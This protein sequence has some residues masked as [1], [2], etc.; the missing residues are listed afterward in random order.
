PIGVGWRGKLRR[1]GGAGDRD[2]GGVGGRSREGKVALGWAGRVFG[3]PA[4]EGGG[5]AQGLLRTCTAR[6]GLGGKNGC[7]CFVRTGGAAGRRW[8]RNTSNSGAC[9]CDGCGGAS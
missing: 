3:T 8:T 1:V 5:S 6:R 7:S 4:A 9:A 2:A